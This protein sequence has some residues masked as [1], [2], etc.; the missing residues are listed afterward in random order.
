[1]GQRGNVKTLD[2]YFASLPYNDGKVAISL[3][4]GIR[5][6]MDASY[7]FIYAF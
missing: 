7:L 6:T 1:M 5:A 4:K 3:L 2:F